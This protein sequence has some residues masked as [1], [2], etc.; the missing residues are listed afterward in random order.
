[1]PNLRYCVTDIYFGLYQSVLIV[2]NV[3]MMTMFNKNGALDAEEDS[4][5]ATS[6]NSDSKWSSSR[7]STPGRESRSGSPSKRYQRRNLMWRESIGIKDKDKNGRNASPK[8][9]KAIEGMHDMRQDQNWNSSNRRK[10]F[11]DE[12]LSSRLWR[13]VARVAGL[14]RPLDQKDYKYMLPSMIR[15]R[16]R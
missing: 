13:F 1:M 9:P 7:S 15:M 6:P 2:V 11:D 4:L 16:A 10:T 3:F 14:S 8:N 12:R 5:P